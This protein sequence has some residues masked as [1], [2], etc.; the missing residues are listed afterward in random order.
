[1]TILTVSCVFTLVTLL[2]AES[3]PCEEKNERREAPARM[4]QTIFLESKARRWAASNL[5]SA[6]DPGPLR[7]PEANV[8]SVARAQAF[9]GPVSLA[10]R[11]KL[12]ESS[13][14]NWIFYEDLSN[15]QRAVLDRASF[16]CAESATETA[17]GAILFERFSASQRATFVAITHAMMNTSIVDRNSRDEIV[18]ALGLVEEM[19][20][21]HGENQS[22]PSD[23]NF[24]SSRAWALMR[25]GVCARRRTLR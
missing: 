12:L 23:Q 16:N 8:I 7:A 15:E 21:V 24:N 2:S 3:S 9:A 17:T 13:L 25:C 11:K 1:M 22:S 5:P 14:V 10:S 19:T 20:D 4:C 18:D 6:T